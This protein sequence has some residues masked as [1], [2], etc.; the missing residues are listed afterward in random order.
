MLQSVRWATLVFA[1][2]LS[3]AVASAQ[4]APPAPAPPAPTPKPQA[5]L[6]TPT[7][8]PPKP[9]VNTRATTGPGTQT[10]DDVYVG[11]RRT[12]QGT[13]GPT[14]SGKPPVRS[15]AGVSPNTGGT[16]SSGG[17]DDLDDLEVER[18]T[19]QGVERPGAGKPM[20]KPGAGTSPNTGRRS[21]TAPRPPQ[22][23]AGLPPV[24]P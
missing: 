22:A 8:R 13:K 1:G 10:E 7:T 21:S 24:K 4:S 17:D 18:R 6:T 3:T 5:S 12:V 14:T 2:A 15:G 20:P 19:V 23:P 11:V 9:P 16:V